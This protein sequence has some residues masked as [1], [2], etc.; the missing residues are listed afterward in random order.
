MSKRYALLDRD[1]TLIVEKNYLSRAEQV[2]LLPGAANA[3]R[4]LRAMG[5]GAILISNQSGIARG[6]FTWDDLVGIHLRLERLLAEQN[7]ILDGI[8]VCP[9]LPE[10]RC[11]CR[12]PS[13]GLIR[14]AALEHAFNPADCVV[15]GDKACDLELGRRV[16]AQ[17][18][19]VLTGYGQ[20][21]EETRL[22]LADYVLDGIGE[23][24]ALIAQINGKGY[25]KRSRCL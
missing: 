10:E 11:M 8:Y 19:L 7:A 6:Y 16:G 1:G 18:C 20:I 12:K 24:P 15:V 13:P 23:L 2:E 17:T 5:W 3:L 22:H 25:D 4:N 9:H 21:F 14:Q